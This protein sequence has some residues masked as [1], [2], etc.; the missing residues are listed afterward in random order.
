M[1][2][3]PLF[4]LL[5]APLLSFA[6]IAIQSST[7][8]NG[9]LNVVLK[10]WSDAPSTFDVAVTGPDGKHTIVSGVPSQAGPISVYL[11]TLPAGSYQVELVS[12][13]P[14]STEVYST[15]KSFSVKDGDFASHSLSGSGSV[16]MT[17]SAPVTLSASTDSAGSAVTYTV[18]SGN[19]ASSVSVSHSVITSASLF[20]SETVVTSGSIVTTIPFT[21]SIPITTSIATSIPLST[22]GSTISG[23]LTPT[24]TPSST[25]A[26]QSAQT[27]QVTTSRNAGSK[28]SVVGSM[29]GFV[30]AVAVA[31]MLI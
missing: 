6:K 20:T 16:E 1:R 18:T 15:S 23:S 2:V 31:I 29:G 25:T 28:T 26:S 21:S 5:A 14:S 13:D 19:P 9:V 10:T 22:T 30:I 11:P 27:A 4:V 7:Y 3:S 17:T 24:I 12:S 8:N